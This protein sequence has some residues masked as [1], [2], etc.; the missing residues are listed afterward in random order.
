MNEARPF[1]AFVDTKGELLV[2]YVVQGSI[3][4][5]KQQKAEYSTAL[6]KTYI[7]SKWGGGSRKKKGDDGKYNDRYIHINVIIYS[8]FLNIKL[9]Q[10][11]YLVI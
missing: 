7:Y 11:L 2:V 6:D 10:L 3:I 5:I 4:V 1:S 9:I 8:N